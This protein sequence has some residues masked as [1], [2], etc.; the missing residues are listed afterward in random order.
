MMGYEGWWNVLGSRPS[1]RPEQNR[2]ANDNLK[3]IKCVLKDN[4]QKSAKLL[5]TQLSY[6]KWQVPRVPRRCHLI[7]AMQEDRRSADPDGMRAQ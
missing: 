6:A 3:K 4:I 1:R 2:K 7:R 5:I